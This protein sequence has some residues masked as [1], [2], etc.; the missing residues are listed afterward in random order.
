MNTLEV[1]DDER[2]WFTIKWP[3]EA[4]MLIDDRPL[5]DFD[6]AIMEQLIVEYGLDE[7]EP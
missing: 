1:Y 7:D 4:W 5:D 6:I 2:G 3:D